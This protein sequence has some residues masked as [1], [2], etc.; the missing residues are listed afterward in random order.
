[1]MSMD[2]RLIKRYRGDYFITYEVP[3]N[4]SPIEL[5]QAVTESLHDDA[6][7][8]NMVFEDEP[9]EMAKGLM[10]QYGF[11]YHDSLVEVRKGLLDEKAPPGLSWEEGN[12]EGIGGFAEM[13][14]RAMSGSLNPPSNNARRQLQSAETE[15]GKGYEK[16]CITVFEGGHPIGI[17][18]PHIEP[19]TV[20]EGRLFYFG[21][22]PEYRGEGKGVAL[23]Q[24]ALHLLRENFRAK[25][26]IGNT[27]A[28]NIPMIHTFIQNGCHLI[29]RKQVFKRLQQ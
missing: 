24:L 23:H 9:S 20:A 19:D 14:E 25:V 17:I 18:M 15:L 27:S 22:F 3:Q 16:S 29:S 8:I 12:S 7:E 10:N 11:H 6:G 13:L 4:V 1:M 28:K 2:D 21:L 26:Y 5:Q